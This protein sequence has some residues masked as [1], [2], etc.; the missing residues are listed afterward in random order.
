MRRRAEARG[1]LDDITASN[2]QDSTLYMDT[3]FHGS[4]MFTLGDHVQHLE[5]LYLKVQVSIGALEPPR[6]GA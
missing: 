5:L 4:L 3:N 1:G 6:E 2:N